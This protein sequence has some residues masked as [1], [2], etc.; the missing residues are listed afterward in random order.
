[1]NVNTFLENINHMPLRLNRFRKTK[2]PAGS[3][4][5]GTTVFDVMRGKRLLPD[6]SRAVI[7]INGR[8]EFD[9]LLGLVS[10][11]SALKAHEDGRAIEVND[12]Y[13]ITLKRD[14]QATP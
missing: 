8:I 4:I 6:V 11:E 7:D 3:K 10:V 13:K 2:T 9:P 12:G 1:M 14:I 5:Y